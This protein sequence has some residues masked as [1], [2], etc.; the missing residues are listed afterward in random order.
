MRAVVAAYINA[1][2]DGSVPPVIAL[3]DPFE[4]E[5]DVMIEGDMD[6]DHER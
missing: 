4:F 5:D 6:P 3:L 2:C 1:G